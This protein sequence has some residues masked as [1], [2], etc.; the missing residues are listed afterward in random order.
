MN[1][2][3]AGAARA[4]PRGNAAAPRMRAPSWRRPGIGRLLLPTLL[5]ACVAM[6][7]SARAESTAISENLPLE[8][9]VDLLMTELRRLLEVDDNQGII[10]LIPRIRALDIDIPDSLYF[11][12]A[13]A[14]YRTG[15]ALAARD[16]LLVYLKNTGREGR[17]YDQASELLLSVREQADREEARRREGE[18][19]AREAL[20]RS[21]EKARTLRI[22]EA[23]RY[24][25][26]LGFP[27][28]ESGDFNKP[29][30]EALAVYQIRRDL[31][32]NGDVTDET[33]ER[34]KA[35]VPLE[36]NCDALARY[37]RVPTDYGLAIP[38][39]ASQ[40]AIPACNDALRKSPDVVRFQI[41]YARALVAADRG[42]D[43]MNAVENAA[44]LGYP[45][46]ELTIGYMHE[47]GML[48]GNGKP[49]F[50]NA[51]R[52]YR[53]AAADD[54]PPALFAIGRFTDEGRGG[55][56][57]SDTG[58]LEWYQQAGAL[59]YPPALS[60]LG[61]RY[62][63]GKGVKRDYQRAL[64]WYNQAAEL[65]Y[66]AALFAIGSMYERGHGVKRNKN[67]AVA[68]YKKAQSE[69]HAEAAARLQRLR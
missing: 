48:S 52:W 68:W 45:A 54:Y 31:A 11:L 34:L 27:L 38:T 15:Q 37:P 17:Y 24:L 26:Q 50:V 1:P 19:L 20:Q 60:V 53:L 40:A 8:V 43:A 21:E 25:D 6:P 62:R 65:S 9:Q 32:V 42:E 2:T 59:G 30:R 47:A 63:T 14:L 67:K 29:T 46:A 56:K 18:R 57:R 66:P 22:R 35:D 4:V 3:D 58:A 64:E 7:P 41:Q 5:I 28:D 55:I 51:L 61:S 44:R 39:I 23:Q 49:D 13:R 10:D 36:D 12:E 33:L 69:G 16:R